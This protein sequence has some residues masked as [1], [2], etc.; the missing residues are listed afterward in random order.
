MLDQQEI[1]WAATGFGAMIL[2]LIHVLR[3]A[4]TMRQRA[5]LIERAKA[6]EHVL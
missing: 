2:P 1:G 3:Q 5:A 6:E 4:A